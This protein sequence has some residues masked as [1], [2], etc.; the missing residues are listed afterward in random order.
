MFSDYYNKGA[1]FLNIF[2]KRAK[3]CDIIYYPY[4]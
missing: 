2:N 4:I 3:L 1:L